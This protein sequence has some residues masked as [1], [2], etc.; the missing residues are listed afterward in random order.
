VA[1]PAR[2]N[3]DAEELAEEAAGAVRTAG[4]DEDGEGSEE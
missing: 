3:K 1:R 2:A 4:G